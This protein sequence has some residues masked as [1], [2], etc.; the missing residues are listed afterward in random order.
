M[1]MGEKGEGVASTE[2]PFLLMVR[3]PLSG[4]SIDDLAKFVKS[5]PS[6]DSFTL[7]FVW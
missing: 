2:Y 7:R 6:I 1:K 5:V 4:E 3:I